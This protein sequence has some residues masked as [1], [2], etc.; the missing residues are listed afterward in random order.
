MLIYVSTNNPF[1][2]I[3]PHA[4]PGPIFFMYAL[5]LAESLQFEQS[6]LNQ[7]KKYR[8]RIVKYKSLQNSVFKLAYRF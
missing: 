3:I 4:I 2:K 7:L 5:K 6:H 1:S 8:N